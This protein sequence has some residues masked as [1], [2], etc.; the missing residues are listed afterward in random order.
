MR[1]S[2]ALGSFRH[3]NQ[4]VFYKIR[5]ANKL[6]IYLLNPNAKFS[7]PYEQGEGH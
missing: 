7:L 4:H 2:D 6:Y 3:E 1:G 5:V